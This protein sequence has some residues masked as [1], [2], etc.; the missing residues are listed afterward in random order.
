MVHDGTERREA[1]VV[2]EAAL[3]VRKEA[4]E[5]SRAVSLLR[6][7]A[8]RK[9]VDRDLGARMKVVARLR[10]DRSYV[11]A[12]AFRRTF[13]QRVPTGCRHGIER[14][15]GWNRSRHGELV[16]LKRGELRRDEVGDRAYVRKTRT[17]R[18]GKL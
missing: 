17:R 10:K 4:L 15:R 18:D 14:S 16:D 11:A 7:P 8:R 1:S 5:G 13:E 6:G 9:I 3:R 12:R 2:V